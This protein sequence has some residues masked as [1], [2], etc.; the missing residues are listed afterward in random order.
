MRDLVGIAQLRFPVFHRGTAPAAAAKSE[1]G[2]L[3]V[4]LTL[5][6]VRIEPGDL[7]VADVDGIVVAPR[8]EA[9]AVLADAEAVAAGEREVRARIE[10]GESTLDVL[11][12]RARVP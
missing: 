9:K 3:R 1:P 10:A 6:G 2:E 11:G 12:L 7:V 4:P 5:R 8:Q